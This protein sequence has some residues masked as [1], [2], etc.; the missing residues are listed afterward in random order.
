MQI[1]LWRALQVVV[2]ADGFS[3][4][5]QVRGTQD[6]H[7]EHRTLTDVIFALDAEE[8]KQNFSRKR[9]ERNL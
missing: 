8:Y 2:L 9:R 3:W 7:Q 4:V 5:S 1:P 6:T